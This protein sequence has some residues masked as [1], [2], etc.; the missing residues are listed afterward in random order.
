MKE[1][2]REFGMRGDDRGWWIGGDYDREEYE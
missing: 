1:E 2:G